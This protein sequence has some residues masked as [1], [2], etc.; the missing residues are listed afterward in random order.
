MGLAAV[1]HHRVLLG[2]TAGDLMYVS[3]RVGEKIGRVR[4]LF[5]GK[6]Q[7]LPPNP[8]PLTQISGL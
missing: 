4:S 6:P 8:P 7:P 1:G 2:L 5:R 3:E